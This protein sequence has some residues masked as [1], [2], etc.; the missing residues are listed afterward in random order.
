M[1]HILQYSENKLQPR[2]K[3]QGRTHNDPMGTPVVTAGDGP[4]AL[5]SS[6]VP[7]QNGHNSVE[8]VIVQECKGHKR[9][10]ISY[11]LQ[12]DNLPIEFHC[13]DFLQQNRVINTRIALRTI[14]WSSGAKI[15]YKINSDCRYV[16]LGVG[17]V[18]NIKRVMSDDA[19]QSVWCKGRI[20]Q[21][22]ANRSSRQ[23]LPT[24][25]SPI[26]SSCNQTPR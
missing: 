23:D 21:L 7:L 10:S 19:A 14:S 9:L 1:R 25:E 24:P 8:S 13:S 11:N 4:E 16:A 15:T 2:D 20:Q 26:S 3:Q 17:V 5:L 12:F 6:C 18:L 22:T